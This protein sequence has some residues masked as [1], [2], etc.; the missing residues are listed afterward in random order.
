[1]DEHVYPNEA[2]YL[3]EMQE[4]GFPN[5]YPEVMDELKLAAKREGLWNLACSDRDFGPGLSL[6]EIAPLAETLGR[7]PH[8][9]PEATNS[10][11]LDT[12]NAEVLA[13]YGTDQQKREWLT[14]L[15]EGRIRSIF[16][17][18]EPEVPS[19]DIANITTS[20]TRRGDHYIINGRKWW[21]T[22]A[23]HPDCRLLLVV[24][25]T[26]TTARPHRQHSVLAVPLDSVG[27]GLAGTHTIFGFH[28]R[29][30]HAEIDLD[31]VRVP[32]S[33]LIGHEGD[34][35]A[36]AQTRLG[37]GQILNCMQS[38]G[39]TA[40]ALDMACERALSRSVFG[41]VLAD[42]DNVQDWIAES[43]VELDMA[44][45]LTLRAAWS[46]GKVGVRMARTE[47]AA[48]KMVVP[49]TALRVIDRAIQIHGAAGLSTDLPLSWM[50]SHQ[51]ALRIAEGPDEV[52]KRTIARNELRRMSRVVGDDNGS[53][54]FG[55]VAY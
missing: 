29:E 31:E 38:I 51:R 14:P 27:V 2:T 40:R 30:G 16:A 10:E 4:S 15:L 35:L 5:H 54:L 20:V 43:R 21:A 24:G 46:I 39:M 52:Q 44:R 33:A 45:L 41:S 48:A 32:V 22:N 1:M 26:S 36:I 18:A 17:M 9:A 50:Y 34:G 11:A 19:S 49:N 37:P 23:L 7:S 55:D 13:T 53:V 42:R 25:R 12:S 47:I 8:L 6:A 3:G 28:A